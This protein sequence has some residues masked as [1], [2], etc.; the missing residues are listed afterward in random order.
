MLPLFSFFVFLFV[1]AFEGCEVNSTHG[2]L[3]GNSYEFATQFPCRNSLYDV[4]T[5]GCCAQGLP[6]DLAKSFC[7]YDGLHSSSIFT[8]GAWAW[9][10]TNPSCYDCTES[11]V[12]MKPQKIVPT[13]DDAPINTLLPNTG[14][15]CDSPNGAYGCLNT[16]PYS[17]SELYPCKNWLLSFSLYG[18]CN[19]IPYSYAKDTCCYDPVQ[20]SYFVKGG[21][22]HYCSCTRDNCSPF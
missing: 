19:G 15:K 10:A 2:C 21:V 4:S 9:N 11:Q 1:N 14:K 13:D 7:C 18:C 17:W 5:Q 12:R 16:Y 20:N 6:F 8:C 22:G 3:N